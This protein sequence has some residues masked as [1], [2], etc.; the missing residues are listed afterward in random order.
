MYDYYDMSV[1]LLQYTN[2]KVKL[3]MYLCRLLEERV[4][5]LKTM[6]AVLRRGQILSVSDQMMLNAVNEDLHWL[7]L[8]AGLMPL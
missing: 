3:V 6:L 1:L 4:N 5:Q 8:I 7:L 2:Q